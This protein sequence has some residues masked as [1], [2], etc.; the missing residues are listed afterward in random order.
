MNRVCLPLSQVLNLHLV[1]EDLKRLI[2]SFVFSIPLT[3]SLFALSF[4]ILKKNAFLGNITF[5]ELIFLVFFFA[6]VCFFGR[7]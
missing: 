3:W 6:V 2:V 7:L 5:A 4:V 1:K